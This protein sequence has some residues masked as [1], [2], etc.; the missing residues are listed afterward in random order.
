MLES[1]ALFQFWEDGSYNYVAPLDAFGYLAEGETFV[2]N[3]TYTIQDS[4]GHLNN[5]T[6]LITVSPGPAVEPA[7]LKQETSVAQNGGQ[8]GNDV[9]TGKAGPDTFAFA[10]NFGHDTIIDF[11][12]GE[13]T[14]EFTSDTFADAASALNAT[15]DDGLGNTVVTV[16]ADNALTLQDVLKAQLDTDDFSIA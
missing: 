9:L 3:I 4:S 2:D 8:A 10:A 16:D 1:G 12:P 7:L 14:I 13:D 5:G 11:T 15:E 6:L